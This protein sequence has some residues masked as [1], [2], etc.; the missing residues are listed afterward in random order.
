MPRA[1]SK[2]QSVTVL[3]ALGVAM[4]LALALLLATAFAA[5][6]G[7]GGDRATSVQLAAGKTFSGTP[8]RR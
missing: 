5:S 7:A 3:I 8:K 2:F 4:A 6:G 1:S